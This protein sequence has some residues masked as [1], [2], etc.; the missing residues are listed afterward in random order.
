MGLGRAERR[1]KLREDQRQEIEHHSHRNCLGR[2]TRNDF[3]RWTRREEKSYTPEQKGVLGLGK[4]RRLRDPDAYTH[5]EL[6]E[7][8]DAI[9]GVALRR[10][11]IARY[12]S[13]TGGGR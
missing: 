8:A 5:T 13:L 11:H 12:L 4:L 10:K 3:V 7:S 2:P 1:G 9:M 6:V